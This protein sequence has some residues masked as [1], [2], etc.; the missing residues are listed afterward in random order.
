MGGMGGMGGHP[1]MATHPG[2][3]PGKGGPMPGQT[4]PLAGRPGMFPQPIGVR[5]G[6]P[7]ALGAAGPSL[8]NP[9][10][11]GLVLGPMGRPMVPHSPIMPKANMPDRRRDWSP[12]AG[13]KAI[14]AAMLGEREKA[15]AAQEAQAKSRSVS[16]RSSSR[17]SSK[18]SPSRSRSRSR[19][20]KKKKKGRGRSDSSTISSSSSSGRSKKSKKGK[21]S[22][23]GSKKDDKDDGK[24]ADSP[25]IQKAKM[26]VLEH[27]KKLQGVEPKELRTKEFRA[28]L[29]NWHPD[30]NPE[31]VEVA[32]AIFQFLQKGKALLNLR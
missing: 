25:E 14:R 20:K 23:S 9:P 8:A 19:K 6:M 7:G 2:M 4:F 21:D 24:A 3:W 5:P 31:N 27:L 13:S 17:S 15:A 11:G 16:S 22:A 26:E 10:P 1:G 30:K 12:H 28:L 18:S 29:R 32:T